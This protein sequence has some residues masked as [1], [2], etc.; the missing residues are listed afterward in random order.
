MGGP[1]RNKL[2]MIWVNQKG[3]EKKFT[4]WDLKRMSNQIVN[5]LIRT[6]STRGSGS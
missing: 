6:G 2:A 1:H 4:F 5:M 3:E